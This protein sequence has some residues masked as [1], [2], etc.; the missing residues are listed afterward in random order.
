VLGLEGAAFALPALTII[1]CAATADHRGP[2]WI[3]A[4]RNGEHSIFVLRLFLATIAC[5]AR[6]HPAR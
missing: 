5:I 2:F 1:A 4:D 6:G 3:E